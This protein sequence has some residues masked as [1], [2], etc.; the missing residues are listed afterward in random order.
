MEFGKLPQNL[1]CPGE[2]LKYPCDTPQLSVGRFRRFVRASSLRGRIVPRF[3]INASL[4]FGFRRDTIVLP[5]SFCH[6]QITA[7]RWGRNDEGLI[8][9]CCVSFP[10]S[11]GTGAE[12]AVNPFAESDQD[13]DEREQET[14]IESG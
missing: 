3:I 10:L 13:V 4:G 11:R 14:K 1:A 8:G 2:N 7:E 12:P 6:Q 5:P 9:W